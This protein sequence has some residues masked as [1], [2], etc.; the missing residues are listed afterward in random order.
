MLWSESPPRRRL[1]R[2]AAVL[3][4]SQRVEAPTHRAAIVTGA[5]TGIGRAV[6][7]ALVADGYSVALVGRRLGPLEEVAAEV[8]AAGG[9]ACAIS[10]DVGTPA[11]ATLAADRTREA[12]GGID[13]VVNNAGT[14]PGAALLDETLETWETLLR[15]NLTSAF[16]LSQLTL[17]DLIARRGCIVN[18]ASINGLVAGPGWTSYCVSKAGLIMLAKCIANDYGRIGVRANAVSPGWVRTPMGDADMDEVAARE[19]TDREGAYRLS[20]R[21]N[22][23]GRPAE[24]TEIASVVAFLASDAA[25]YVNGATIV[26]DGGTTIVDATA[27]PSYPAA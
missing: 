21:S 2:V 5:G 24:A 13:A 23:L 27:E 4:N 19:G 20:H 18:V 8:T 22:P 25:S 17:P 7:L 6:A 16:L 3:V 14:G 11:G 1:R 10:A 9:S 12:F 26:V 15:T